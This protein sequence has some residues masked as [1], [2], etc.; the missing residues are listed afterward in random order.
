M[1]LISKLIFTITIIST[2]TF[3]GCNK[4]EQNVVQTDQELKIDNLQN[5]N[6]FVEFINNKFDRID[7]VN[8]VNKVESLIAKQELNENELNELA[9]A[10]GFKNIEEY[11]TYY[12]TQKE[13]LTQLNE[14]YHLEN[15]EGNDLEQIIGNTRKVDNT[16]ASRGDR[17]NCYRINDNCVIGVLAASTLC[18]L[19]CIAA[20]AT[21]VL[22]LICHAACLTMQG[23]G[24]DTCH[25]N[26][27]NCLAD[28]PR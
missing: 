6:Q 8:D 22:G 24:V 15:L 2:L 12:I 11:T 28:C 18:N 13:L 3:I 7:K 27:D 1:N 21:V 26:T 20:D 23:V 25:A 17:C 16:I 9:S 4:D 5:D 14:E 10:L 19:G